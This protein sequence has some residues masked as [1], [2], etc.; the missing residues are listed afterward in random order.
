MI[1]NLPYPVSTNCYW[2]NNKGRTHISERGLAFKKIVQRNYQWT[3]K[4]LAGDVQLLITLHPKLTKKGGA[5]KSLI[6][7]DNC[8]KCILDSL[9]NVIYYD[10]KQVKKIVLEYGAPIIDGG[11]TVEVLSL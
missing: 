10:D 6:D 3:T 7:L 5:S 4:L 8:T 11:A 1:L 2:R 9:I